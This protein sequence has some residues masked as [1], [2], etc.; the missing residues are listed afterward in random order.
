MHRF[1]V[2]FLREYMERVRTKWF[3][4]ATV[5]GPLLLGLLLFLPAYMAART[6][7]SADVARI[8]ILDAT[9]SELGGAVA[10]ALGGGPLGDSA[11]ARWVRVSAA[12]LA[13]AESSAVA[14]VRR[15]EIKGFLVLDPDLLQ[16]GRARYE[17]VNATAIADMNRI[18]SA[19][20]REYL[21][22]RL[23]EAG[24][25]DMYARQLAR[26]R[27][28]LDAE[29]LTPSGRGGKGAVNAIFGFAVGLLLYMTIVFFG[30][31]VLR[32]VMEEKQSRV[33][34]IVVSSVR[35]GALLAGK[36]LGV[37]AVGLTQLAIWIATG[38]ALVQ[39]RA[40]I[41]GRFGVQV[42]PLQMPAISTELLS[43]LLVFFFLGYILYSALFAAVG[44]M[45]T[46]EQEA[47]QAQIP[48][49]LLLVG[50]VMFLQPVLMAP[51][52]G[53]AIA[54]SLVPLSAPIMMPLRMTTLSV[55]YW[56]L[57]V[58]LLGL[59][60]TSALAVFLAGRIYRTGLLM[61][62][63]RASLREVFRWILRSG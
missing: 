60:L 36:V 8:W 50:T 19:V 55:P 30:Q 18:E 16:Q 40:P 25:D 42:T 31:S 32:G 33:A 49:L 43:L 6:A 14:A 39:L 10:A 46:T 23:R 52:S 41:L 28:Q 15:K 26:L 54:L 63:K 53:M 20:T 7:A 1:G 62:G 3:F 44:A 5:F 59:G 47:Q 37:G 61:Y 4:V 11:A 48:V 57:G 35:P 12:G 58:S 34:E 21:A 38:A 13:E 51:E 24:L 27:L 56:Q 22:V 45:V 2:V 17:G 9:D 29:R